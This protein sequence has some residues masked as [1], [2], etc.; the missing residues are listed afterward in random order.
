MTAYSQGDPRQKIQ[1]CSVCNKATGN[2]EQ[3]SLYNWPDG[4][5]DSRSD[6]VCSECFVEEDLRS[7]IEQEN[8]LINSGYYDQRPA[9]PLENGGEK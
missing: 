9:D 5:Y 6:P 2:C 3:D 7:E 4:I 8:D 1:L